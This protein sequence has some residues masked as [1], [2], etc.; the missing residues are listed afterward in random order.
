MK[1]WHNGGLKACFVRNYDGPCS[2]SSLQMSSGSL[3]SLVVG[4]SN[5]YRGILIYVCKVG[6][7]GENHKT[8][9]SKKPKALGCV[10][11]CVPF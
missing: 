7:I 1:N 3:V 9:S 2:V 8:S 11:F 5:A 4:L 6:S 10:W